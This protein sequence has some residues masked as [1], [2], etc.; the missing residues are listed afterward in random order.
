MLGHR[1]DRLVGDGETADARPAGPQQAS[2]GFA[3]AAVT[4][5]K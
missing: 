2:S 1:G 4:D 3:Q 5:V